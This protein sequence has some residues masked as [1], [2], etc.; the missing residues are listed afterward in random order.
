MATGSKRMT[1]WMMRLSRE[2]LIVTTEPKVLNHDDNEGDGDQAEDSAN[3][4]GLS[5][6]P[7]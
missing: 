2:V 4:P 7:E 1:K 3:Y 6:N 5:C